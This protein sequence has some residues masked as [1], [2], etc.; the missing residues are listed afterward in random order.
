MKIDTH[1]LRE[2]ES[3]LKTRGPAIQSPHENEDINF[4]SSQLSPSVPPITAAP[5]S[6]ALTDA[7]QHL[8]KSTAGM[9]KGLKAFNS[10]FK[11]KVRLNYAANLSDSVLL[12]QTLVKCV[13]KGAQLIDK[14]SNLQ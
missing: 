9:S 1:L 6:N 10:E 14:V 3:G 5:Q 8:D 13:G 12:T 7:L 11:E 2:Y 4:F